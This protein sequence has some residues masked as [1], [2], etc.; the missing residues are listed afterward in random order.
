MSVS[1]PFQ[2]MEVGSTNFLLDFDYDLDVGLDIDR[3]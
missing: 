1:A 3:P 2:G